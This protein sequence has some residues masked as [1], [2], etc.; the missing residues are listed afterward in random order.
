M[1]RTVLSALESP[2][3]QNRKNVSGVRDAAYKINSLLITLEQVTVA[4]IAKAAHA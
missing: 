3:V 2:Q 4:P 1:I